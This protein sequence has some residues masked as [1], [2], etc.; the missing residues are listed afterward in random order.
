[1]RKDI[2]SIPGK[3]VNRRIRGSGFAGFQVKIAVF[4][5]VKITG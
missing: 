1:M 3:H 4:G 2:I 5:Y